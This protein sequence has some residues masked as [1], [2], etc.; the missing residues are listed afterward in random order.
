M[1]SDLFPLIMFY[2]LTRVCDD[3]FVYGGPLFRV[4]IFIIICNISCIWYVVLSTIL[5]YVTRVNSVVE[6]TPAYLLISSEWCG[7]IKSISVMSRHVSLICK[8]IPK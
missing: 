8:G 3:S 1:L 4:W 6:Q 5:Y 2:M 7:V